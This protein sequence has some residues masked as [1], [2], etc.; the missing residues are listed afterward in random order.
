MLVSKVILSTPPPLPARPLQCPGWGSIYLL[1]VYFCLCVSLL[2]CQGQGLSFFTPRYITS[3]T[4][5]DTR[6]QRH[7]YLLRE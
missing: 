5:P 4:S 2:D 1:E 3:S 6:M 7:K